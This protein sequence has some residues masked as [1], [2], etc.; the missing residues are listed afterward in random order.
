MSELNQI[1]EATILKI[2]K[3]IT[4][5]PGYVMMGEDEVMSLIN[6]G[7]VMQNPNPD[8]FEIIQKRPYRQTRLTDDGMAIAIELMKSARE[9]DE[10]V[11]SNDTSEA[12]W[13]Q[14]S[15]NQDQG[16]DAQNKIEDSGVNEPEFNN[17]M[18]ENDHAVDAAI[19]SGGLITGNNTLVGEQPN[20]ETIMNTTHFAIR[21]D[22][23]VATKQLR[24]KKRKD[25]FPF[26]LLEIGQSFHVPLKTDKEGKLDLTPTGK[27]KE[28]ISNSA[29]MQANKRT[30]DEQGVAA[31]K[32]IGRR[33]FGALPDGSVSDPDGDGTRVYR[34][35]LDF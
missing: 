20:E 29:I 28:G 33:V 7:Y 15:E 27:S 34:V 9:T 17:Q 35:A 5:E 30:E 11:P 16:T 18:G 10:N 4:V 25:K 6:H 3:D 1:Q 8:T 12:A 22:I 31:K 26:D 13:N 14:S 2:S 23:P 19:S 32:F 24:P 21:N